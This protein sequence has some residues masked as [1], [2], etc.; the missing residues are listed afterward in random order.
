MTI[1]LDAINYS[2][3]GTDVLQNLSLDLPQARIGIV[4]RNGSG[5]STLARLMMGLI[6]PTSGKLQVDGVDVYKDRKKALMTI[7]MIFQNPD[8]QIIFPTCLEEIAFGLNQQGMPKADAEGK[9]K[10]IL[11]TEGLSDWADKLAH[12]LSQGQRHYL[13]LLSIL[14][15]KPKV[16]VLDEPYAG[17]DI[18]TSIRLQNR[19]A[20]LDQRLILITHDPSM[21]ETFDRVLWID[22]GRVHQDGAPQNI[23]PEFVAAMKQ[24]AQ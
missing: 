18:A 20:Q 15:M 2:I 16:I 21:I 13:C 9:A 8:H 4:G 14:A 6:K 19:L 5:K 10:D 1:T 12:T 17:L 24:D 11:K 22:Q 23:L 7:G 3:D